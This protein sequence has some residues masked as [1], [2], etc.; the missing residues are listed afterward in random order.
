MRSITQHNVC[1]CT[2]YKITTVTHIYHINYSLHKAQYPNQI[3]PH[4]TRQVFLICIYLLCQIRMKI[5]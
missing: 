3:E 1:T 4:K 5:N 2:Q